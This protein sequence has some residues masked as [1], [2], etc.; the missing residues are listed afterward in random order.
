MALSGGVLAF[1]SIFTVFPVNLA[2]S[3]NESASQTDFLPIVMWH[4]MGDSCCFPFSLGSIKKLI[5][6]EIPGIRVTSLKIGKS[7]VDD[8][9]SGFFVHPN[10]QVEEV[11]K[12]LSNDPQF[13]DGFHAIGFSQGG[14]FLRALAQR[15]PSAKIRNLISLGGQHQGV[16]GLPN[17]PS[18]SWKTCEYFRKL[19]NYA[20]YEKWVQ[21]LLV[22]ATYWHDPLNEDAYRAGSSFLSDINNEREIN[23]D[24]IDNLQRL[25]RFVMVKF[26]NDT[27]VQPVESQWFGF[28]APGSDKEILPLKQSRI[29]L[30]DRLGLR[31]MPLVF[32]ECE[33]NHLQFTQKWFIDHIIPYLKEK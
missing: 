3:Q 4:G 18:L 30:Q 26:L 20:A 28:Y 2:L 25:K 33:G 27:I 29:Y 12:S 31:S 10:K 23:R 22:Q 16:F 7:L 24:Y 19:L 32:V 9:E 15:C 1:L 5:E 6:A 21:N 13:A 14:Q 11:C 17:C 8:Y